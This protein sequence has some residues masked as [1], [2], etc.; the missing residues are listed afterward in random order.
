MAVKV[1]SPDSVTRLAQANIS[2]INGNL[3]TVDTSLGFTPLA[4]DIMELSDYDF[5]GITEQIK[6]FYG[7][8][9]DSAF[10]DGKPQYNML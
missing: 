9:R 3:I 5:A 10:G 2:A 7:F 8:M 4:G 6:F 1:R